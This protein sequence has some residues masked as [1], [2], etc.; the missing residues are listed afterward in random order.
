[1]GMPPQYLLF[2]LSET[3]CALPLA[4]VERVLSAVEIT[5]LPEAPNS[6]C[7]VI[8]LAGEVVPVFALSRRFG[9]PERPVKLRDK[10]I[11]ACPAGE[12]LAR[13][14]ALL[15][16]EAQEVI[17]LAAPPQNAAG[18]QP[19]TS[20]LAPGLRLVS[21]VLPLADKLVV[22]HD[23]AAFLSAAEELAL[24][25]ALENLAEQES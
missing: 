13:R 2:Q 22:I 20:P 8:N 14:V 18:D 17:T 6:V 1:M 11:V 7:G 23:L 24:S 5:P 10:L 16:D 15:A 25:A 4:N 21:G 3:L 12:Q 19:G 9:L